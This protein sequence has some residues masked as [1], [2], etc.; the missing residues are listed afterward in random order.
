MKSEILTRG[1]RESLR[2]TLEETRAH[3]LRA[4]DLRA[5]QTAE[6]AEGDL[7]DVAEGVIE[8]RER[9]ALEEHDRKLL[10]EVEHALEKLDAGAYGISEASGRPIP[11]ERLRAVPWARYDANEAE[12]AEQS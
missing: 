8:D 4:R 3:L 11:Y 6:E 1:Q 5:E 10:V 9:A 2:R 7:E 12:R